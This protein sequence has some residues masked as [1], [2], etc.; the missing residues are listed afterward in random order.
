MLCGWAREGLGAAPGADLV[1]TDP[2]GVQFLRDRDRGVF[3][4]SQQQEDDESVPGLGR[5]APC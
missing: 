2:G 3:R 4:A 5:S 1:L